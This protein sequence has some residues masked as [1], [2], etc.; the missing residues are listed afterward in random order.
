MGTCPDNICITGLFKAIPQTAGADRVLFLEASNESIDYQGERVLAKA[1]ANSKEYFLKF[2]NIDLDHLTLIGPK[3]GVPDYHLFEIGYPVEVQIQAPHTFVK[4]IIYRGE[5][6]AARR[7]NEVWASLTEQDPPARWYPSV[8]GSITNRETEINPET[9]EPVKV[10]TDV[11]WCNVG[12]SKTPVN[13][14][15]ANAA[16]VPFGA[17]AKSWDGDGFNLRKAL[18]ASAATDVA[19]LAGGGALAQQSLDRTIFSYWDFRDAAARALRRRTVKGGSSAIH[20]FAVQ[21]GIPED[22]A[23]EWTARFVEDLKTN[24]KRRVA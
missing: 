14:E 21:R 10:V 8:G 4:S 23:A 7:A 15:V 2:G 20:A 19:T 6:E 3:Q 9:G 12:L 22:E 18:T 24:L 1:L 17:F 13:L 11:R 16:V 5:G